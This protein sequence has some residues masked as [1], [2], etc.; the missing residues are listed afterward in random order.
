MSK[1][2]ANHNG[3]PDFMEGMMNQQ[4][5][6]MITNDSANFATSSSFPTLT[7]ASA[8]RNP[9][10]ASPTIEPES[11]GSWIAALAGLALIGFCLLLAAAGVWYFFLR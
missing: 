4:P 10:P 6:P 11:T 3:V 9:I 5:Q 8:S 1:L 2:D 7:S